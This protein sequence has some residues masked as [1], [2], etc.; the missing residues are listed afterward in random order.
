MNTEIARL[1]ALA[2][3]TRL[4]IIE[5]LSE[6]RKCVNEIFPKVNR[7]QSTVS[8][9][10]QRSQWKNLIRSWGSSPLTIGPV[11]QW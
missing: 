8:I 3:E 11:V 6:G 1:K 2:D 9:H 4:N 7:T 10:R 5:A